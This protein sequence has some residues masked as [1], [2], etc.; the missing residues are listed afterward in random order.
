MPE[1]KRPYLVAAEART[2]IASVPT[3]QGA[4]GDRTQ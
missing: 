1:Y 2:R 4:A 3:P